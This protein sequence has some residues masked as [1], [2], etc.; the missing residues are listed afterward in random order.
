M[1]NEIKTISTDRMAGIESFSTALD[2]NTDS[3]D[4]AQLALF[5]RGVDKE[6][7]VTEELLILQPL[8]RTS[9]GEN[10]FN[11]GHARPIQHGCTE[12]TPVLRV[13]ARVCVCM[14]MSACVHGRVCMRA[15]TD[16]F[17]CVHA[18]AHGCDDGTSPRCVT[19]DSRKSASPPPHPPGAD[20]K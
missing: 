12:M 14:C 5:I 9:R 19:S 18:H 1:A 2:K 20:A 3:S 7:A 17:A 8:K 13:L 15:R 10:I 16:A 11:K 6:F 4:T